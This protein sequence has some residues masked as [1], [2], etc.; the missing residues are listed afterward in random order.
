[1]TDEPQRAQPS[2]LR[3]QS[4]GATLGLLLGLLAGTLA[5][6]GGFAPEDGGI[7][8][9][10]S[11][12]QL[13]IRSLEMVIIPMV[14]AQIL[15]AVA[16]AGSGR[17]VGRLTALS[18]AVFVGMLGVAALYVVV[19]SPSLLSAMPFAGSLAAQTS[20][21]PVPSP[22]PMGLMDRL[23]GMVPRNPVR[24]AADGEL[25]PV[26]VY[27]LVLGLA[28]QRVAPTRRAPLVQ[29]C[30]AVADASM[31][32]IRWILL[33]APFGVFAL[34]FSSALR[35]GVDAASAIALYLVVMCAVLIGFCALL[36]PL[37]MVAGAIGF[38]RFARGAIPAQLVAL[39]TRS[40]LASL[41]ALFESANRIGVSRS[42]S[43]LT[44]PLAVASFKANRPI[45]STTKLLLLS[46][47]YGFELGP[48]RLAVFIVAAIML[49]FTTPGIPESGGTKST[50]P[51]YLAAGAP[52]EGVV[53]LGA[54]KI[55]PDFFKT[56]VNVTADLT[57]A[58]V[59][60]RW[61]GDRDS[62]VSEGAERL[63][64]PP[65]ED[66]VGGPS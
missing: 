51:F 49:S 59:V 29:A 5:H 63:G 4:I 7:A 32:L 57:A 10:T 45:S 15:V 52:L 18:L 56:L 43:S 58:I 37:T 42:T 53:L 12:G 1:M 11:L 30:A 38:A 13:W 34:A 9:L 14:A 61:T 48:D 26:L 20:G 33:A 44:L 66:L 65:V 23:L 55:I 24:A 16:G 25:L 35:A 54:S 46:H 40:S 41:P 64:E 47:L 3:W 21:A 27:S 60:D 36:Y 19:V 6:R 17:R 2:G 8:T 28:L 50:L 22:T 62:A 31:V 39:G